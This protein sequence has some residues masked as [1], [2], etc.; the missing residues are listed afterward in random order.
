MMIIL[1]VTV[2]PVVT[3]FGGALCMRDIDQ[4]KMKSKP[5]SLDFYTMQPPET[6]LR[7]YENLKNYTTTQW[8]GRVESALL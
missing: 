1:R 2:S 6:R 8:I 5:L 4:P 7:H 3:Y